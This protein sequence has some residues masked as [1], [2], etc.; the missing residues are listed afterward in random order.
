MSQSVHQGLQNENGNSHISKCFE[1]DDYV[2]IFHE[3]ING[4]LHENSGT[5][6]DLK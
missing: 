2:N 3:T 6:F 1:H 5:G 4:V